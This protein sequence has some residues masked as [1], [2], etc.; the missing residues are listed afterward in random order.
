MKPL[1]RIFRT[2]LVSALVVST[3]LLASEPAGAWLPYTQTYCL[4]DLDSGQVLAQK[5]S[6]AQMPPASTTKILT[7]ALVEDY[8]TPDEIVTVSQRAADT[9]PSAV[10]IRT[11]DRVK[12]KDLYTAMLLVSANDA[13]VALAEHIAGSEPVFAYMMNK[14][15]W[16][17]GAFDSHFENSNGL[18]DPNHYSSGYDLFL[19]TRCALSYPGFSETVAKTEAKIYYPGYPNGRLVHNT[20]RLLYSYPGTKGVKTGTTSAAGHCLVALAERQQRRLV[21]IVLRSSNRYHDTSALF[22]FGFNRFSLKKVISAGEAFKSVQVEQGKSYKLTAFP[23]RDVWLYIDDQ[24]TRRMEKRV[25]LEYVKRAPIKK[26]DK[27]GTLEVYYNGEF[28]EN[29]GLIAGNS[30]A[31]RTKGVFRLLPLFR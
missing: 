4:V 7:A 21:T 10:G 5:N 12:V 31:R 27:L 28:V 13:A 19:L 20:N 23:E 26:G 29:T 15:A 16:L 6:R 2:I 1:W 9:P 18:P 22:D 24:G 3:I 30:V 8:C 25:N 17:I 11:G 14:K